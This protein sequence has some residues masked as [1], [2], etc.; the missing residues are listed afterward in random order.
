[1]TVYNNPTKDEFAPSWQD[2]S[3]KFRLYGGRTFEV[4]DVKGVTLNTSIDIGQ[5]R[6]TGGVVVRRTTGSETHTGSVNLYRRGWISALEEMVKVAPLKLGKRRIGGIHFDIEVQ[7]SFPGESRIYTMRV[8]GCRVAGREYGPQ[9][10]NDPDT[11]NIPMSIA[12][13]VDVI[14]GEEVGIR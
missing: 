13:I 9:E 4:S 11:V 12:D 7:H 6:A 14:N 2:I 8:K 1:M 10:G 3:L 5:Q